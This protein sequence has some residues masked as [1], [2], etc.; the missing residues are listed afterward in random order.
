MQDHQ[1]ECRKVYQ[2]KE[3]RDHVRNDN[4]LKKPE[5]SKKNADTMPR[6]TDYIL[7]KAG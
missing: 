4:G 2:K 3:P 1:K 6:Q 7:R 5:K